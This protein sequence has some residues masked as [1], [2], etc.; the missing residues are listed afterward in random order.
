MLKRLR[1]KT[2][3]LAFGSM[4][5]KPTRLE[6]SA[7]WWSGFMN[8]EYGWYG[9]DSSEDD[10]VPGCNLMMGYEYDHWKII[11]Y[12]GTNYQYFGIKL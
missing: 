2:E 5:M 12:F 8:M 6:E 9:T 11:K 7:P 10:F 1:K 4:H 3:K